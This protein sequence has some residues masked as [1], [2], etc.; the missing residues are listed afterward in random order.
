VN[1]YQITASLG[2]D[3]EFEA[4][5]FFQGFVRTEMEEMIE[6]KVAFLQ[7]ASEKKNGR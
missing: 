6:N 2:W 1:G 7:K 3:A 5:V 4:R